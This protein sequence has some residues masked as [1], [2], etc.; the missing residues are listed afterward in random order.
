[1]EYGAHCFGSFPC[2][3]L[4]RCHDEFFCLKFGK[5]V[6]SV[7]SLCVNEITKRDHIFRQRN[8]DS[9]WKQGKPKKYL[10]LAPSFLQRLSR[11]AKFNSS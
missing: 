11:A 10:N 6:V 8:K 5:G 3:V 2:T 1:M 4:L 7:R 9:R